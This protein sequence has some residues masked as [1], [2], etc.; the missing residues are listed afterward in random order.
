ML[1][2]ESSVLPSLQSLLTRLPDLERGLCSIYHKKVKP[3]FAKQ[4][5]SV[6]KQFL[7]HSST[8]NPFILICNSQLLWIRVKNNIDH[9]GTK[10]VR[11]VLY[12]NENLSRPEF[13]LAD[14]KFYIFFARFIPFVSGIRQE[15]EGKVLNGM[16]LF[17]DSISM[18][19]RLGAGMEM[20]IV[21]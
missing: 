2:S 18:M 17:I 13:I 16:L 20:I 4:S 7:L 9:G 14:W 1:C 11:H 8:R 6:L 21:L 3:V 5:L 12:E 15:V 10:S 19:T